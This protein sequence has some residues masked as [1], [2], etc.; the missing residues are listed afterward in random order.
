LNTCG[1]VSF[2]VSQSAAHNSAESSS[3][4]HVE[5]RA[6]EIEQ[7]T[8]DRGQVRGVTRVR[9]RFWVAERSPLR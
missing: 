8:I 2:N 1:T 3:N 4:R 5:Q 6:I 7:D 9:H